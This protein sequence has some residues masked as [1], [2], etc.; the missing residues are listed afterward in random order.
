MLGLPEGRSTAELPTRENLE[1]PGCFLWIYIMDKGL[2]LSL[3]RPVS[4]P[5]MSSPV[6][7]L[8][9]LEPAVPR[10]AILW[11]LLQLGK[12]QGSFLT[13][14]QFQLDKERKATS[15]NSLKQQMFQLK[16][17]MTEVC[18]VSD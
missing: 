16:N 15:I 1:A 5:I 18:P 4:L 7:T 17:K 10:S 3:G 6:D 12:I 14:V 13:E 2:S 8:I 11:T 9:P